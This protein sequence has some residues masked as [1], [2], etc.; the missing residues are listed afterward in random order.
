[1]SSLTLRSGN[2]RG[3]RRPMKRNSGPKRVQHLS[4]AQ[5]EEAIAEVA[6]AAKAEGVQLALIGGVALHFYG[7]DRLTTDIDFAASDLIAELPRGPGLS[8]G[9]EQTQTSN[10]IP[11]DLVIRSDR[12]APLYEAAIETAKRVSGSKAPVARPEYILAMKMQ[13]RRDKDEFDLA[14]LLGS[15]V[16]NVKRARKIVEEYLGGYAEEEFDSLVEEFEWKRSRRK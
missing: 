12:W 6:Q 7:S 1:M 15:A 11:I 2:G 9:G 14:F 3:K 16:I 5:L 4:S 10:G 13:A 8:F